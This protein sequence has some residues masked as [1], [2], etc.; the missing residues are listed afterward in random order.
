MEQVLYPALYPETR[1]SFEI[2]P[3]YNNCALTPGVL[4]LATSWSSLIPS[5]VIMNN[6]SN[7]LSI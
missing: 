3:E 5:S 1:Q 4:L 7:R 2:D 6:L